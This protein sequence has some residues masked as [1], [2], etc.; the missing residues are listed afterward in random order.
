M[1]AFNRTSVIIGVA[2]IILG[3]LLGM[4]LFWG[5]FPVQWTDAQPYDLSPQARAEYVGLVADSFTVYRDRDLAANHFRQWRPEEMQQAFADAIERY[6]AANRPDNPL[7]LGLGV[8]EIV[9][10]ASFPPG[11][12]SAAPALTSLPEG[13]TPQRSYPKGMG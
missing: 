11:E 5:A 2:G 4:A 13:I 1:G 12:Q 7:D 9:R 3:L 10:Q 8:P 6:E